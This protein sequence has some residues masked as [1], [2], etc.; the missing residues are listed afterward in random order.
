ME[1]KDNDLK[2][3]YLKN[4]LEEL[5]NTKS[6]TANGVFITHGPK[7]INKINKYHRLVRIKAVLNSAYDTFMDIFNFMK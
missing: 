7:L 4:F 2:E 1:N 5:V 6:D 3:L